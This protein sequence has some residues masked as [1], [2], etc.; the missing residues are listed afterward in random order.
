[1]RSGVITGTVAWDL[2]CFAKAKGFAI[3]A[4]SCTSSSIVNAALE[5]AA[6][7]GRPIILR[8]SEGAAAFFCGQ[9]LPNEKLQAS[10]LGACAIAHYVRN[11]APAYGI[12]VILHSEHCGPEQAP[13]L[14]GMIEA[15]AEFYKIYGEPLISSH[16]LGF[17][18]ER[19]K[20]YLTRMAHM[21]LIVEVEM[22]VAA[23]GEDAVYST[24]L[25]VDLVC[26]ELNPISK[27]FIIAAAI[28]GVKVE[29]RVGLLKQFQKHMASQG[30]VEK[31]VFFA[32]HGGA[33]VTQ[34]DIDTA[35]SN[36]VVKMNIES[37]AEW[38]YWEG[39]LRFYK[40]NE[41]HLQAQIGNPE[42]PEMPNKSF[43][44][45]RRW[46]RTSEES[47]RWQVVQGCEASNNL[48]KDQKKAWRKVQK[49][50]EAKARKEEEAQAKARGQ[51]ASGVQSM[52]SSV[53]KAVTEPLLVPPTP[54]MSPR[55]PEPVSPSPSPSMASCN[56][57]RRS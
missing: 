45:P 27:F 51:P 48:E 53:R 33:G 21:D 24:D 1:M 23:I 31:P 19:C 34:R 25:D 16:T 32:F 17:T 41:A 18:L 55:K 30:D 47:M 46:V 20:E 43:Y 38:A 12:P 56:R 54:P 22:Q 44:D 5:G 28:G 11:V 26:K 4:F 7:F 37:D 40:S 39:L 6:K 14:D 36:G 29:L 10:I 50:E 9:G 15:D 3:P 42:G 57:R 35:L 13:W 2:L 49:E 52:L 8:F